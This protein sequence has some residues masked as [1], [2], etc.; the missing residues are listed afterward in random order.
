MLC[1]VNMPGRG[2]SK[3]GSLT[4]LFGYFIHMYRTCTKTLTSGHRNGFHWTTV[5][6]RSLFQQSAVRTILRP[7]TSTYGMLQFAV[8]HPSHPH[9]LA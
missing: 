1:C 9:P 5:L 8:R 2:P 6:H 3:V 7:I 4:H